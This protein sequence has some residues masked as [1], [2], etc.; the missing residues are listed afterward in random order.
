MLT[1]RPIRICACRIILASSIFPNPS[2]PRNR[3]RGS[4][5]CRVDS[6]LSTPCT[7]GLGRMRKWTFL[8]AN[9]RSWS[10][11]RAGFAPDGREM[12]SVTIAFDR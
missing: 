8:D 12:M 4:S 9:R 3:L 7:R 6:R 11:A 10:R 1:M 2:R 5:R